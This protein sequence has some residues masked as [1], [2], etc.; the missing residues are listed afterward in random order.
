MSSASL[1]S[2][3]TTQIGL[4]VPVVVEKPASGM[5][6]VLQILTIYVKTAGRSLI[7]SEGAAKGS[8]SGLL[9]LGY[10]CLLH[11]ATTD[12]ETA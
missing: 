3:K 9:R 1:F 12:R 2:W 4:A 8:F 10:E 11:R 6:I 7:R 5:Q